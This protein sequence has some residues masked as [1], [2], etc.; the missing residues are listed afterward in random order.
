GGDDELRSGCGCEAGRVDEPGRDDQPGA[1]AHDA[2][3][4]QEDAAASG[5]LDDQSDDARGVLRPVD[6]EHIAH[7]PDP[8]AVGV[9]DGAPRQAGD[10][11]SRGAHA[12]TLPA[13]CQN[14]SVTSPSP[15][16]RRSTP[17]TVPQADVRGT[18]ESYLEAQKVGD[19]LAKADFPVGKLASGGKG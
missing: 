10:E 16:A 17:S 19:R 1:D 18:Y 2:S 14:G 4:R 11:D 6:D 8:V 15:F 9:E 13:G 12:E 7:P 3:V 5:D